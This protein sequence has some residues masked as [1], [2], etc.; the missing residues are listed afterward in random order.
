[1]NETEKIYH[2][3]HRTEEV[4]QIIERMPTRF[5][6]W[7]TVIVLS[8]FSLMFFFGYVVRYPDVVVGQ[9]TINTHA[10]PIKLIANSNGKLHLNGLKS[11]TTVQENDIVAYIQNSGNLKNVEYLDSLIKRYNPTE[12]KITE[13]IS[14]L[15]KNLALGE[16]N[17]KYYA[18]VNSLQELTN[19]KHDKLFEKQEASLQKIRIEQENAIQSSSLK[20][21]TGANSLKYM[22]KFHNR[23]S[24]LLSK[25]V[26]SEADF[27][28]TEITYLNSKDN[29]QNAIS[30]LINNRQQAQQTQSKIQETSIQKTEKEKELKLAVLSTYIDLQDNIKSWEQKYVFR[31]PFS[32]KVQFLKFWT[33]NQFVQSGEP[34]FTVIPKSDRAI[35]Q[36]ILPI[37]GAGKVKKGQEVIVK[38]E[39]Y[40]Y[41]EYGS[42]KGK[43]QSISLTTNTTKTEKGDFETYM[44]TIDFPQ[45]LKT[46]YGTVLDFK[47]EAK[48]T[49]EIITNDRRLIQRLFDNL[50]YILKK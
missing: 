40:P 31:A 23:D 36:L 7:I 20:V 49:A 50:K 10:A 11:L 38:L 3:T 4:Q 41:M 1:M 47:F 32:G 39:D 33:N 2:Q 13:L 12:D 48:G 21:K 26:V 44:I 18:F 16:L 5:G 29:Y 27:D 34:V 24:T 43:V 30:T 37:Q 17:S 8:L 28:K 25:K 19:Y 45:Q 42:I 22:Q 46:N 9:I 15:P 14:K 35:G 6:L